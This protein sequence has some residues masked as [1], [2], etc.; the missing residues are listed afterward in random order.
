[1]IAVEPTKR[2]S[3]SRLKTWT[4]CPLQGFF[5][6]VELM[7]EPQGA[8]ATYGTCL[9]AALHSFN[10]GASIED[11][12][13]EFRELWTH[14]ETIGLT[15]ETWSKGATFGGLLEHG[16]TVLKRYAES[17][18]WDERQVIC[19]E[20]PFLVP[21]GEY[22]LTG[23]VDLVELRRGGNGHKTLRVIDYKGGSWQP[24]T[25][26][27]ILDIQFTSYLWA[28]EQIEFWTGNGTSEFPAI[29]NGEA[30]YEELINVPRRAIWY[31]LNGPKEVDAGKRTD[32]DYSRLYRLMKEVNKSEAA[33]IYVPRIGEACN[34]CGYTKECGIPVLTRDAADED[35]WL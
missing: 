7:K 35:R 3:A 22:E 32:E 16:T 5:K 27:L 9:H 33:G 30:L 17:L 31:H 21:F 8:K 26:E 14:P 1:M 23:F 15:P 2:W 25:A 10:R 34:L 29:P 18:K 19:A 28:V 13:S 11:A 6:Y 20:H 4:A 12:I 24:R